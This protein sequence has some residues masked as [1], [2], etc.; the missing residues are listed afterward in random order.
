MFNSLF[1]Q[2]NMNNLTGYY[3][4]AFYQASGKPEQSLIY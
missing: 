4:I 1:L 3:L 2:D